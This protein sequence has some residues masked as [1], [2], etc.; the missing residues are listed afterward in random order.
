MC[1]AWIGNE[2]ERG[3]SY[4]PLTKE[5]KMAQPNHTPRLAQT[6]EAL[7][8]LFCLIDD[9]YA[10]LNPR[11][12]RYESLTRLSDSEVLALA[13]RPKVLLAPV[14]RGCGAVS[15][16]VPSAGEE[17]AALPGAPATGSPLRDGRRPRDL[18]RR[19]DAAFGF[20]PQAGPPG[21]GVPGRRVGEVGFLQ[22]LRREAP[23]ALRHQRGPHNL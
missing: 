15:L 13:R 23:R 18:A 16:L 14:P 10:L 3:P 9:A 21:L 20:A 12:R 5:R 7:T 1:V 8:V 4:S 2:V 19:L 6:E 11:A 17:V 22:R